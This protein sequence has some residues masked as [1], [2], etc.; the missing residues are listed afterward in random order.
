MS[1]MS[2]PGSYLVALAG[3]SPGVVGA[4]DSCTVSKVGA[5]LAPLFG[6]FDDDAERD[7]ESAWLSGNGN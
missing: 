6:A 5:P 4:L 3:P 1:I 2:R 7:S